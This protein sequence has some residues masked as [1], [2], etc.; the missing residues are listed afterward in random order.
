[1]PNWCDNH[2]VLR[3]NPKILEVLV[4]LLTDMEGQ[5]LLQLCKPMPPRLKLVDYGSRYVPAD[6]STAPD[7]LSQRPD[8]E[9]VSEWF[10][11]DGKVWAGKEELAQLRDEHVHANWYDWRTV[12][13]G[14]KWDVS[15]NLEVARNNSEIEFVALRFISAWAPPLPPLAILAKRYSVDLRY[16]YFEPGMG[17]AG[18]LVID[19]NGE[20]LQEFDIS[21]DFSTIPDNSFFL[22][23]IDFLEEINSGGEE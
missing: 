4:K 18:R 23:A 17:F 11:E 10:C 7:T 9:K 6:G 21:S 13:W 8:W 2:V 1:M 3:G 14:T 22:E 15:F 19:E 12:N 20:D 16:D 5:N